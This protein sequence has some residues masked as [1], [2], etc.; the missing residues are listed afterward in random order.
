MKNNPVVG[1]VPPYPC[2]F[3]LNNGAI[4]CEITGEKRFSRDLQQGG[5][6]LP[7]KLQFTGS[8]KYLTKI[9]KLLKVVPSETPERPSEEPLTKKKQDDALQF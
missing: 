9:A 1:H 3:F 2:Y 6:E 4:E 5:I 7:S 8:P